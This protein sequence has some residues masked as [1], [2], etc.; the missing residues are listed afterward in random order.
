MKNI[1]RNTSPSALFAF[2][3]IISCNRYS[4]P[5]SPESIEDRRTT[6]E[7]RSNLMNFPGDRDVITGDVSAVNDSLRATSDVI[8]FPE[9][10]RNE[11]AAKEVFAV[12]VFA[13]KSSEEAAEFRLSIAPLF[14][15][16][17]LIDYKPPYYKVR[18]GNCANLEE[19]EALLD[20]VK[21]MGFRSA[22]LV[23]IRT[24]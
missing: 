13:S 9:Y 12:Q 7:S 17:S 1:C 24:Q 3:A 22:W 15:E 6:E 4:A 10:V 20:K 18:V 23:R 14:A 2:L 16:E 11:E 21:G 5:G 19:A 8:S